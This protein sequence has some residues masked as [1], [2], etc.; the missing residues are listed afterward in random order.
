MV[1]WILLCAKLHNFVMSMNDEWTKDNDDIEIEHGVDP[2]GP[3]QPLSRVGQAAIGLELLQR[4]MAKVLEFN[5]C[6]CS[7]L[8]Q[9]LMPHVDSSQEGIFCGRDF[10]GM[11]HFR[12][13]KR[14]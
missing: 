2:S 13:S 6:P 8:E 12:G 9:T 7:F 4:V 11:G 10:S 5:R 3:P 14:G 1:C